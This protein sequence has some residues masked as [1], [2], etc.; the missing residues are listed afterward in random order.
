MNIEIF[1]S[2]L[3]ALAVYRLLSPLIDIVNPL[4]F[5]TK[6]KMISAAARMSTSADD[7]SSGT[8]IGLPKS[9]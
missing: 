1:V 5:L 3:A 4:G 7:A 9:L 2:T 8:T 6:P